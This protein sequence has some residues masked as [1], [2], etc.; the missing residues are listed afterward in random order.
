VVVYRAEDLPSHVADEPEFERFMEEGRRLAKHLGLPMTF[1][2][3]KAVGWEGDAF[4]PH[5][6]YGCS[7]L[8]SNQIIEPDGRLKLCC[9]I[10]EDVANAFELGPRAA[11][12]CEGVVRE[13]RALL[14]GR[15][16]PECQGCLYLRER[17][18][19][20]IQAMINEATRM[21][22][23]DTRL[24]DDDRRELMETIATV[25]AEKDAIHPHH[26]FTPVRAE[27]AASGP[28]AWE[29]WEP[30]RARAELPI[31]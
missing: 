4:D 2:R 16:R 19:A 25:Q 31:Y 6:A 26:R 28:T 18:P 22:Y 23:L 3:Q 14:E 10:E 9:Y 5:A 17:T 1:W 21:T 29:V 15:V 13:R 12:N 30:S 24:T 27:L 20:L 8:W 11:F 7:Q